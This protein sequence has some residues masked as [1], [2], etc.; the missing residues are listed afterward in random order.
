MI[1]SGTV[2]VLFLDDDPERQKYFRHALDGVRVELTAVTTSAEAIAE[3]EKQRFDV[4]CLDHDLDGRIF[5]ESGPGTGYE[6]AERLLA[7]A[8]RDA[9][10]VVHTLNE[11]GARKM[12]DLLGPKAV[13]VPFF[14]I[15]VITN[16]IRLGA[17]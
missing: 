9:Q 1:Q 17:R 13:W 15:K 14:N 8:N 10:V 7:T 4:V 2:K 11:A 3:L 16:A 6:V 5:V 12:L